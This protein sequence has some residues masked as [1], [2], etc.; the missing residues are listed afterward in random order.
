MGLL[1]IR[2]A[3]FHE[4]QLQCLALSINLSIIDLQAVKFDIISAFLVRYFELQIQID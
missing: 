2:Q 1:V 4:R 3:P